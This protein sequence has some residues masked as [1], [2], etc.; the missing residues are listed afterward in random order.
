MWRTAYDAVGTPRETSK[1]SV[2]SSCLHRQLCTI[3]LIGYDS[4]PACNG[5]LS[6]ERAAKALA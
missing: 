5:Y 1:G 6:R 4:Q 2:A 3:R